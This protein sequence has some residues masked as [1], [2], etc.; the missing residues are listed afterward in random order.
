[1][2][3]VT[4]PYGLNR[5]PEEVAFKFTTLTAVNIFISPSFLAKLVSIYVNPWRI[6]QP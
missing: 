4:D 1:V 2:V 3:S 5:I 6:L